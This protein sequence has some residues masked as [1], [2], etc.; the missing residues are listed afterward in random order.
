MGLAWQPQH[1]KLMKNP[2]FSS[3]VTEIVTVAEDGKQRLMISMPL[4]KLPGW[5]ICVN[6]R[7]CT[8][9]AILTL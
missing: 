4:R 6:S 2:R 7:S 8:E 1:E 9:S 5:M 3:T